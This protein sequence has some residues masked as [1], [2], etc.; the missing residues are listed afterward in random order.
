MIDRKIEDGD[1]L[2]YLIFEVSPA[3]IDTFIDLDHRHWTLFLKDQPGFISKDVWVNR[4]KP[5][6]V[7]TI[8][9]W[10]SKQD[11]EAVPVERVIEIGAKFQEALGA[12]NFKLIKRVHEQND[13]YK[14]REYRSGRWR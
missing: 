13:L 11:W 10:R 4:T 5:G 3:L 6:E 9:C 2:E 1:Y 14:V 12:E 7:S 8:T